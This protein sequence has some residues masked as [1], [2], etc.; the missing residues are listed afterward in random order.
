VLQTLKIRSDRSHIIG[1]PLIKFHWGTSQLVFKADFDSWS[2]FWSEV[3]GRKLHE[4]GHELRLY[5]RRQHVLRAKIE[6]SLVGKTLGDDYRRLAAR[7]FAQNTSEAARAL[8]DY[9]QTLGIILSELLNKLADASFKIVKL[10]R[11]F[12]AL[13]RAMRK[14]QRLAFCGLTIS[15][16][17]WY[18]MH[19]SHPPKARLDFNHLLPFGGARI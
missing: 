8:D 15:K 2:T 7:F 14:R 19:G 3:S 6:S 9:L 17:V 12:K 13:K 16:K 1:T 10:S 11:C 18:L 5:R 4:L